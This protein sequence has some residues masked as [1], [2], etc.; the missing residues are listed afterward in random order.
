MKKNGLKRIGA[1]LMAGIMTLSMAG[2]AMAEPG[3]G[4]NAGQ[5]TAASTAIDTT[6]T[7]KIT[8]YKL[9]GNPDGTGNRGDGT[10]EVTTETPIPGISFTFE[11]LSVDVVEYYNGKNQAGIGEDTAVDTTYNTNGFTAGAKT[12]TTDGNGMIQLENLPLGIYRVTEVQYPGLGVVDT[13]YISL[14]FTNPDTEDGWLY[15]AYV[16]PKNQLDAVEDNPLT[17]DKNVKDFKATAFSKH[18]SVFAFMETEED[19]VE[20]G[21]ENKVTWQIAADLPKADLGNTKSFDYVITDELNSAFDYV[22]DTAVAAFSYD[23]TSFE[24][25][26]DTDYTLSVETVEEVETVE[27]EL[28]KSGQVKVRAAVDADKDALETVMPKVTITF[29]TVVL[30]ETG[31]AGTEIKNGAEVAYTSSLGVTYKSLEVAE[32]QEPEVHYGDVVVAKVEP[33]GSNGTKPL[34]GA[35]FTFTKTE[36][37]YSARG[38]SVA[39]TGLIEFKGL[40]YSPAD[41]NDTTAYTLTETKAPDGYNLLSAPITVQVGKDSATEAGRTT[42][43]NRKGFELPITGGTGTVA[44]TVAGVVL[45]TAA[46]VVFVNSKKKKS[47]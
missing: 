2:M 23:G 20:P 41:V 31:K 26:K 7:G 3:D 38:T 44:T 32:D 18:G 27:F 1:V 34:A 21:D 30:Y 17:I 25:V 22:N 9:S 45:L 36:Y 24:L 37:G 40:Y 10:V 14:P 39:D 46:G 47:N 8:L 12:E 35:E 13:F 33:D 43:I 11:K 19:T 28:S 42:V 16:Y 5:V 6:K 29:D 4:E 15:D